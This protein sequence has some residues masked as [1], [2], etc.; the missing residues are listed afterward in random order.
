[1]STKFKVGDRVI[2]KEKGSFSALLDHYEDTGDISEAQLKHWRSYLGRAGKVTDYMSQS[3][4]Y[5]VQP[6]GHDLTPIYFK[7]TDIEGEHG[8]R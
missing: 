8:D 4:M 6:D 3:D 5:Q 1:M 2:I 7:A